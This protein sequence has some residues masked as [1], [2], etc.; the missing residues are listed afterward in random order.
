MFSL[1]YQL[2]KD[3]PSTILLQDG[4]RIVLVCGDYQGRVMTSSSQGMEGFS[5]GWMNRDLIQSGEKTPHMNA[6]GGEE[7]FWLGPEGG[8]FSIYFEP[9]AAF[10]FVNWQTPAIID[11]ENYPII[12]QDKSSVTFAKD[13]SIFNY[14]KTRFD[15][16]IIRKISLLN[17]EQVERFLNISLNAVQW[18]AY[19]S[20]N[21][22]TNIGKEDWKKEN[23]LLSIWLLGMLN[24]SDQNTIL[25]PYKKGQEAYI[26]DAYFGKIDSNRLKKKDG[27]LYFKGDAN[28]RGKLGVAPE[29]LLPFAAS[30]DAENGILTIIHFDYQDDQAYVNSMWEIQKE[31]FKGDVLNAYNDGKNDLG[32]QMGRFY[33]LESSSPAK[34]LKIGESVV[35]SQRT[36]HFE[37]DLNDLNPIAKKILGVDLMLVKDIF[38]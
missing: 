12:D 19:Q 25:I 26:N 29:A 17:K 23:G 38:D 6:Y 24:A 14:S 31:P 30:Y 3:N 13:F 5:Y 10:E 34:E 20:E 9:N 33:E 8:Q 7:R 32:T 2:L 35:H 1:D 15:A 22:L 28:A 36:F 37:G 16:K 4:A 11:S 27:I 21:T 18:V